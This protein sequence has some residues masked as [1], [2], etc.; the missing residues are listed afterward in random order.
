[1]GAHKLCALFKV[2]KLH[3]HCF[4]HFWTFTYQPPQ[5]HFSPTRIPEFPS[6][7]RSPF[8]G[9]LAGSEGSN[10]SSPEERFS[11]FYSTLPHPPKKCGRETS[12]RPEKTKTVTSGSLQDGIPL[13]DHK[14]RSAGRLDDIHRSQQCILACTDSSSFSEI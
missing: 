2:P 7:G 6:K 13:N 11:G 3:T 4:N 8:P 10:P 1:M 5:D 12:N 9:F 14:S